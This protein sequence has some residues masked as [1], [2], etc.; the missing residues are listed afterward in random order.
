MCRNSRRI[1]ARPFRLA[2][3]QRALTRKLPFFEISRCQNALSTCW[4][5]SKY[6]VAVEVRFAHWDPY[7]VL[8][9]RLVFGDASWML[10]I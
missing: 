4:V 7:I 2:Q 5:K 9:S 3:A 6:S 8:V 1:G 10:R